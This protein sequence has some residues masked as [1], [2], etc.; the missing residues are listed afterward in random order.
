MSLKPWQ[1]CSDP[2]LCQNTFFS[3]AGIN[4]LPDS[5][6][7]SLGEVGSYRWKG[8]LPGGHGDGDGFANGELLAAANG[9]PAGLKGELGE[10]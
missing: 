4:S 2:L 6:P 1:T 7:A 10:L 3:T 9:F 8:L 5:Q